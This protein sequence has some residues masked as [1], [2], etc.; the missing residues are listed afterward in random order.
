MINLTPRRPRGPNFISLESGKNFA[1]VGQKIN[2]IGAS[3]HMTYPKLLKRT[4]G[5]S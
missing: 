5:P 4:L 2:K 1:C 3:P